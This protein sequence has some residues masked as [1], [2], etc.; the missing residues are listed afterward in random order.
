[1]GY[2]PWE[3]QSQT[4]LKQLSTHTLKASSRKR[5]GLA[6]VQRGRGSLEKYNDTLKVKGADPH[7]V[8]PSPS[9]HTCPWCLL[10]EHVS[11][12]RPRL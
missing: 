7:S 10:P 8:L 3:S 1:M 2:H 4:Q 6:V 12:S 9:S 5:C 11:R